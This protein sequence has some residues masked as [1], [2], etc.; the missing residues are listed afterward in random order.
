MHN[1]H[2]AAPILTTLLPT[3]GLAKAAEANILSA[4]FSCDG[5]KN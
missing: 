1:K 3:H 4:T 5:H 2:N